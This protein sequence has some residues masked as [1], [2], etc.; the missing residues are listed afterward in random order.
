M[1]LPRK[2]DWKY[3]IIMA[4]SSID[5]KTYFFVDKCLP[6]G[7]SI[8]CSHF[9][10]F[11][12]VIAY[13]VKWRAGRDNVNYLDDYP[14]VALLRELCNAQTKIFLEICSEINFPV[15]LEKTFWADTQMVFL[16]YLIDTVRQLI[17]VL[18]EKI[19]KANALIIE[20]L[21]KKKITL[22]SL[23]KICGFLNF[24]AC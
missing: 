19:A 20:V 8:S 15:S 11:S 5:G 24:L 3:L 10:A 22:K 13:L 16:G 14:F 7:A 17:M 21:Q 4:E 9:Q 23:Q 2:S 6:F 1:C 18:T 12:D